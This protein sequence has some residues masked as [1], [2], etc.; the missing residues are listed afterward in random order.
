MNEDK[1]YVLGLLI[2][3]GRINNN[4][5]EIR[6]PVR[7]W[8]VEDH[9]NIRSISLDLATE[10]RRR[11]A[12]AFDI[13]IDF[14]ITR[15]SWVIVPATSVDMT[16]IKHT[17]E[18]YGLPSEGVLLNKAD[19]STLREHITSYEAEYFISGIC[20][21]KGSVA[22]SHRRFS[23]SAPTISI[24]VPGSTKNYLFVTQLCSWLHDLGAYADQILYNNPCQHAPA[25][26]YYSGWK[27]GFKIRFLAKEFM[28]SK[29]FSLRAKASHAGVLA[30]RQSVEEQGEC[31]NRTL[32]GVKPVSI[33]YDIHSTDIPD[34]IRSRIFLH[35]FHICALMKCPY[36]P[37]NELRRI[38]RDYR[39]HISVLPLLVK[40]TE[41][42]MTS[43]YEELKRVY[44]NNSI[45]LPARVS[46]NSLLNSTANEIY[47]KL[48]EAIAYL[49]SPTLNG[50]R[51]TGSMD[52]IIENNRD[53]Y[54]S[55]LRTE[56]NNGEPIMISNT[57]N[58]RTAIVS[59]ID[60]P[61]NQNLLDNIVSVD[62]LDIKVNET[63]NLPIQ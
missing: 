16:H 24:E 12:S 6:L 31:E 5:F 45:V 28:E 17:L 49:F 56:G 13:V 19:I 46:V 40:G 7:K 43:K 18:K 8:G 37:I 54:V 50:K 59:S 39:H 9:H 53:E 15:D 34:N 36:A 22:D 41:G 23:D 57:H 35:Y 21:T 29:S 32:R 58:Q 27:K 44:F 33:H 26:P 14:N 1:A 10:V 25:D 51:H 20:D 62:D 47:L 38:V 42:E 55:I 30:S 11:F 52:E 2:G 60:S 63:F 48:G 61:F 4:T 3:G